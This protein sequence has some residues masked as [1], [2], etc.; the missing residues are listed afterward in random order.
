MEIHV[1][2]NGIGMDEETQARLFTSFTQAD[3]STTRRFGGTGLGLVISRHLVDLMGGQI[4][5]Q[6]TPGKGSTFTVRL[7]FRPAG[8]ARQ[9]RSSRHRKWPDS[10]VSW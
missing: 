3:T 7:Q 9:V 1:A 5:V 4:T 10:P 2:D 6:S 8:Q